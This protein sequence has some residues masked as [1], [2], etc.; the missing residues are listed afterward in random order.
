MRSI[1]EQSRLIPEPMV[2]YKRR[3]LMLIIWLL[4]CILEPS[5]EENGY[6]YESFRIEISTLC[7]VSMHSV[8]LSLRDLASQKIVSVCSHKHFFA[9]DL[10][11]VA[12]NNE[13]SCVDD[14]T[15]ER[16]HL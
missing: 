5:Y 10:N 4:N 6:D 11:L 1:D 7:I 13:R 15:G 8:Q 14:Q 3:W 2:L 16:M 12:N 9:T